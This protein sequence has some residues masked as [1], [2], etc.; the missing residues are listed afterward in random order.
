MDTTRTKGFPSSSK[1]L[2]LVVTNPCGT[3]EFLR[4]IVAGSALDTR[5]KTQLERMQAAKRVRIT[6]VRLSRRGCSRRV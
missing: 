3:R 1:V 4:W 6:T 2:P 5:A